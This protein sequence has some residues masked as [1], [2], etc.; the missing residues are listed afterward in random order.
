MDWWAWDGKDSDM[1]EKLSVHTQY[2]REFSAQHTLNTEKVNL[3]VSNESKAHGN[4]PGVGK[5]E[6]TDKQ[7]S[8][9]C[10]PVS[11]QIV[12]HRCSYSIY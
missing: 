12:T 10:L 8:L 9:P 6:Q 2:K 3:Y 11:F 7:V 5:C 4:I 1:T